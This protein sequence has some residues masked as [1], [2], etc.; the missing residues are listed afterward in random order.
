MRAVAR[1]AWPS[2]TRGLGWLQTTV[3]MWCGASHPISSP[4]GAQWRK[5]RWNLRKKPAAEG[6]VAARDYLSLLFPEANTRKFMLL[7]APLLIV[8]W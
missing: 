3:A 7:K 8:T 6:Y 4:G 2:I 5:I 1:S